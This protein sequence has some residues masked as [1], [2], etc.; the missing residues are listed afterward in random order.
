MTINLINAVVF[1]LNARF[2]QT[3]Q[4]H[5]SPLFGFIKTSNPQLKESRQEVTLL[6]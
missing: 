2:F 3:H 4:K 5:T 1:Q 6:L